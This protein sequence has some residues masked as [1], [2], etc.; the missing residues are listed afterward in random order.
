MLPIVDA[1]GDGFG[2]ITNQ[3]SPALSP[4]T[5]DPDDC[6]DVEITDPS[7]VRS[8]YRNNCDG[9]ITEGL[10]ADYYLNRW[11]GFGI[12]TQIFAADA[13]YGRGDDRI[14]AG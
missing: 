9:Q 2:D 7:P 10:N 12:P 8:G 1:D 5:Y 6:N 14:C 4:G 13:N 3:Q 11:N